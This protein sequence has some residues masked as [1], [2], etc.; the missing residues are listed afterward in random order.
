MC[1]VLA[2][3]SPALRWCQRARSLG[4]GAAAQLPKR[5]TWCGASRPG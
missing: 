2:P 4:P 5:R 1:L 3:H